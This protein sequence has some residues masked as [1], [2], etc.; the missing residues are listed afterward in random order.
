MVSV[1]AIHQQ[2][3]SNWLDCILFSFLLS[4]FI[5]ISFL[6]YS[7]E[8][9]VP[10][11]PFVFKNKCFSRDPIRRI[12]FNY[13]N[14]ASSKEHYHSNGHS[15]CQRSA[16]G[17]DYSGEFKSQERNDESLD[18]SMNENEVYPIQ[19][20]EEKSSDTF[21]IVIVGSGWAGYTAAESLSRNKDIKMKNNKSK[22]VKITLLDASP[23]SGGLAGGFKTKTGRNVE[24]GI[25]G[26]WREYR[27]T[28]SIMN[29][30]EGVEIDDVLG[31]YTP[32]VLYSKNGRVALAPV[33]GNDD[34]DGKLEG[35]VSP[36]KSIPQQLLEDI[37]ARQTSN[38]PLSRLALLNK[39]LPPPIDIALLAKFNPSS[40][41]T[42]SDRLSALGLLGPWI[43]FQQESSSSWEI[44]DQFSA[45]VLFQEKAGITKNLFEEM[46]E[47][48]LSVLPMSPD[49]ECSAAAVLS[50][51]HVFALQSKGAFDVR[52]CRGSIKEKIFDPWSNQLSSRGVEIQYNSR[53][54][55][56]IENEAVRLSGTEAHMDFKKY[57]IDLQG[58]NNQNKVIDC[59]A[60][61]FAVGGVAMG[62]I[63]ANS[64]ALTKLQSVKERQ[65]FKEFRGV[66]CV[67]VRLFIKPEER[68][69][70]GLDGGEYKETQLPADLATS[71]KDSPVAVCGPNP[72][73]R[74]GLLKET[75]FCIYDLQRMHDE[76][77][78]DFNRGNDNRVAVLE[79]DYYRADAFVNMSDLEIAQLA[80][81][82]IAK[83]FNAR[84]IPMEK[85]IDMSIVRARN[86]V[87]HF[88]PASASY[89]PDVKLDD[90]LYICGD[91]VERTQHASWSTEKAVVTG[92]KA[93]AS[94]STDF[95]LRETYNVIIDAAQDTEQLKN[96][97]KAAKVLRD[98]IPPTD[99]GIPPSPWMFAKDIFSKK[100]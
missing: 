76:F 98:T 55:S 32:S 3:P 62:K 16:I 10:L 85:V 93:A 84:Q 19:D 43:D 5:I 26:F 23:N 20:D 6:A 52:W 49:Y 70:S 35:K 11:A 64:P 81:E 88:V 74:N 58:P 44:Y 8:A 56:V 33:L 47:P 86:A 99:G 67:A 83:T 90:G 94:L 89:S 14:G 57:S 96:L 22:P 60:I 31:E 36:N 24:A 42:P 71:M 27:N 59:D 100:S 72:S 21:D 50:C 2:S 65:Y 40:P 95:N 37:L 80:L 41:L 34:D 38:F 69:T 54:T 73:I 82:T 68:A 7:S 4:P 61:V 18:K 92:I 91:W 97:R 12:S 77:S 13:K 48:L 30:I 17:A 15:N 39:Y 45:R 9:F 79:V 29:C 87:S 1:I 53:V 63:S 78:V 51:F 25:H 75:G 66:T 28:F 46:I